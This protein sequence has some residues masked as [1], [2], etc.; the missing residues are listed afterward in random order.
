MILNISNDSEHYSKIRGTYQL[1]G[2]EG[3]I[4]INRQARLHN[5]WDILTTAP[6]IL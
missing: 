3:A 4:A 5:L 1:K 6:I 2:L